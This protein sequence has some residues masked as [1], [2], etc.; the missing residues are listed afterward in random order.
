MVNR[1]DKLCRFLETSREGSASTVRVV[2]CISVLDSEEVCCSVAM[3]NP[4]LCSPWSRG[5]VK[6]RRIKEEKSKS[7]SKRNGHRSRICTQAGA[8]SESHRNTPSPTK[9]RL[10]PC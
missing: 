1:S 8:G 5:C 2:S 6:E 4:L 10:K 9:I 3:M 7:K